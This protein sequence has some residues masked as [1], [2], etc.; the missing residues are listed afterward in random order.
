MTPAQLKKV[1]ESHNRV[2]DIPNRLSVTEMIYLVEDLLVEE[3]KHLEE[4]EPYAATTIA[5][6]KKARE[7]VKDLYH[8]IDGMD[9]NELVKEHIWN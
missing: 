2:I 4:K 3:I 6:T 9:T 5:E 8:S 1:V 7:I